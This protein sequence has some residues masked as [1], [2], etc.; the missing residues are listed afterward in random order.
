MGDRIQTIVAGVA[1]VASDDPALATAVALAE[2]LNADLHLVHA[3][4]PEDGEL[5]EYR[6][7]HP[8]ADAEALYTEGL[9]ARLEAEAQQIAGARPGIRVVVQP[10]EPDEVLTR[11]ADEL[12]ADLLVLATSRRSRVASTFL[13]STAQLVL[14]AARVP[15]LVVRKSAFHPPTHR[16]L[17]ATDLSGH[18]AHALR[19]GL[20]LARAIAGGSGGAVQARA[21]FVTGPDYG[22]ELVQGEFASAEKAL[23]KLEE[24]L[25]E[26]MAGEQLEAHAQVRATDRPVVALEST[27][28]AHGLPRPRNL[29]VGRAWRRRCARAAPVPATVAVLGGVPI[30][31]LGADAELARI[32]LGVV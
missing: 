19:L 31:G 9:R 20:P 10:G 26:S 23:P 12:G 27:V 3:A 25:R 1:T 7:G 16:V 32:A 15:M 6:R 17:A 14:R 11:A 24:F 18:S 28:L 2:R 5:E 30:V 21:L 29:E 8:D 22:A 4:S 13:G